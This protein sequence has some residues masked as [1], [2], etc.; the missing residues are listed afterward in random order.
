MAAW[1]AASAASLPATVTAAGVV[2]GA[3]ITAGLQAKVAA[4]C[5]VNSFLVVGHPLSGYVGSERVARSLGET[6]PNH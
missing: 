2:A 1:I 3:C 6:A 5:F 4:T